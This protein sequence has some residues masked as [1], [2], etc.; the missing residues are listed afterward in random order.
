[1][2]SSFSLLPKREVV[3]LEGKLILDS[4]LKVTGISTNVVNLHYNLIFIV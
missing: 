4:P 1:M 2:Q 3:S